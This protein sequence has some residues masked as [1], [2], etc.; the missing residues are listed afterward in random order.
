[1]R[2]WAE[3]LPRVPLETIASEMLHSVEIFVEQSCGLL[4]NMY[5]EYLPP[6]LAKTDY[7]LKQR[8]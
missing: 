8:D 5:A 6:T 3:H 1:L 2:Y 4:T 7:I